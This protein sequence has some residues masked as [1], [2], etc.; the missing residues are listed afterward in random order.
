MNHLVFV[1]K[2]GFLFFRMNDSQGSHPLG[3]DSPAQVIAYLRGMIPH[4]THEVI[5]DTH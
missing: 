5:T 2:N 3:D 4:N 1:I